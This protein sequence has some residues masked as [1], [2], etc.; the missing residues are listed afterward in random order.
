MLPEPTESGIE[1]AATQSDADRR[2]G[3]QRGDVGDAERAA[4]DRRRPRG[5][6]VSA[7]TSVVASQ[8]PASAAIVQ[9]ASER[10]LEDRAG[11]QAGRARRSPRRPPSLRRCRRRPRRASSTRSPRPSAR[12]DLPAPRAAREQAAPLGREPAS[13]PDRGDDR[14]SEQERARLAADERRG[15]AA[16]TVPR[17]VRVVQRVVG[18]AQPERRVG[19]LERRL[20]ARLGGEDPRRRPRCAGARREAATATS[21]RGRTGRA[22]PSRCS[23]STPGPRSSDGA[24][25][26][27][28]VAGRDVL[29]SDRVAQLRDARPGASRKS[30]SAEPRA[31]ASRRSGAPR[32]R[33]PCRSRGRRPERRRTAAARS[34]TAAIST[35]SPCT[36]SARKK[37][38]A[39]DAAGR[40]RAE[41]TPR[42]AGRR[43]PVRAPCERRARTGRPGML[44]A[45][46][47]GAGERAGERLLP[48]DEAAAEDGDEHR[49]RERDPGDDEQRPQR[50][51][52]QPLRRRPRAPRAPA[53]RKR[54][55]LSAGRSPA[56]SL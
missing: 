20:G 10:V 51:G 48:G 33:P 16:A 36:R 45:L 37:I 28:A 24:A 50:L 2:R 46:S 7:R 23:A 17:R 53:A 35:S 26:A 25:R 38:D 55:R 19:G 52:A 22:A 27:A 8:P 3:A 54:R 39:A 15:G 47:G 14:E 6:V 41:R 12:T 44:R 29:K 42:R 11:R 34:S 32:S 56:K 1:R 4:A 9:P 49:E 21:R 31:A 30:P 40:E 18:A 5:S 13:Q 43:A